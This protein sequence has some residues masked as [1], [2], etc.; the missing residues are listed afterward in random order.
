MV[1]YTTNQVSP[2]TN[3]RR[4]NLTFFL[5]DSSP[6]TI[7]G[8]YKSNKKQL[9]YLNAYTDAFRINLHKLL[10]KWN[11]YLASFSGRN[12]PSSQ[13]RTHTLTLS[14]THIHTLKLGSLWM[15]SMR[16]RR[17]V[18]TLAPRNIYIYKAGFVLPACQHRSQ[19]WS[20]DLSPSTPLFC[21][22]STVYYVIYTGASLHGVVYLA[23][24][25]LPI[26]SIGLS[27][28]RSVTLLD[29]LSIMSI[30]SDSLFM[31]KEN[32][33]NE[34]LLPPCSRFT[35]FRHPT[36]DW[37]VYEVD[38]DG[39]PRTSPYI[40]YEPDLYTVSAEY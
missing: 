1:K 7:Y 34:A 26:T 14:H 25:R 28:S 37:R 29:P 8:L 39:L 3:T 38:V 21:S 9:L 36:R 15:R 31:V 35:C 4:L 27:N 30:A 16:R 20:L 13:W 2:S 40:W 19:A 10:C 22:I 24:S 6:N 12:M 33:T 18:S 17:A 11:Y 23:Y 32:M 5:N